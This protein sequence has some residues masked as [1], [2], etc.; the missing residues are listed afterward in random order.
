LKKPIVMYSESIGPFNNALSKFI[1][2]SLLNKVNLITLRDEVSREHLVGLGVKKTPVCL[3]ADPAF[4]LKPTSEDRISEI[5]SSEGVKTGTRPVIGVTLSSTTNLKEETKKSIILA[6]VS[7]IYMLSRY[8]LPESIIKIALRIFK[9]I[10]YFDR[11]KSRYVTQIEESIII[12]HIIENLDVDIT[13]VPHIRREGIFDDSNTAQEIRREAKNQ[14]RIKVIQNIYTSE[15]LKGI[16][17][18]CDMFISSR[19]HAPIAAMSQCIPTILIPVSQRHHGIMRMMGQ[20]KYVCNSFTFDEVIPKVEDAWSNRE[21]IKLEMQSRIK[22]IQEAS[23]RN[24]EL[25]RDLLYDQLGLYRMS[26]FKT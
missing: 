10:G 20:E 23:L 22:D 7:F 13:I 12:D 19:M 3:T 15:E 8:F 16:I 17:R 11:F 21:T 1:A 4:L 2:K 25:V 24:S 18:T 5:L 26:N 9:S 6:L 14:G